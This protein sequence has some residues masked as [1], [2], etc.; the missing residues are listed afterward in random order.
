MT[1]TRSNFPFRTI[2]VVAL[3]LCAGA[4]PWSSA[5][6]SM[7]QMILV[8]NWVAGG[9]VHR[10]IASRF[11]KAITSPATFVFL[12]F[13]LLHI[14]GLLWTQDMKWGLD[15]CRILFPILVLGII[16]SGSDRL[17]AK[18]LRTVLLFGAWNVIIA[19]TSGL[20]FSKHA[21]TDYRSIALFISHIRLSLLLC[22]AV[23]FLLHYRSVKGWLNVVQWCGALL[24]LYL[25][26]RLGS[27]QGFVILGLIASAAAWRWSSRL[28][29]RMRVG[30]HAALVIVP[31]ALIAGAAWLIASRHKPM[32]PG[33]G[34]KEEHTAGGE[35]YYHDP[36]NTQTENGTYVWTY[37]AW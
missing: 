23:V 18:E 20:I 13:L 30:L 28:N 29:T 19:G 8:A 1:F 31:L 35:S 7:A 10:D 17:T 9:I 22:L 21:D 3:C 6:T 32:P 15:L 33:F 37:L 11:R 2:H 14:I 5:F 24:A 12:S 27:V 4:I 25:I 34:S 26:N 36:L 16:L